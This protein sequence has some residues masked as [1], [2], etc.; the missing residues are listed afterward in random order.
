MIFHPEYGVWYLDHG[1]P[2]VFTEQ[3]RDYGRVIQRAHEGRV[4]DFGAHCGFFNVYL[5]KSCTPVSVISVEPDIRMT[6]VLAKNVCQW[7]TEIHMAAVVDE[8]FE[9]SFVSLYLGKNF[10]ATNSIEKFRGRK[11]VRVPTLKFQD[12]LRTGVTFIKC[13]CEGAEYSLNWRNLPD[14]VRTIAIEF[15]FHR[16]GWAAEMENING[17]LAMQG[18]RFLKVPKVNLF[19]KVDMGLYVRD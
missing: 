13:D 10:S 3:R 7:N 4:L 16:P 6:E 19:R 2:Y 17:D 5:N 8:S 18:F 14:T 1:D 9:E 11:E 12:L 15:H